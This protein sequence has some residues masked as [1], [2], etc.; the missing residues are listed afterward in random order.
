MHTFTA[1]IEKDSETGLFVGHI[2]G[3]PGAYS[4][5]ET[6]EELKDNLK[7]V[8]QLLLED[9]PPPLEAEFVGTAEIR[10]A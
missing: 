3:F 4:Q 6:V 1:V 2:P 5:G 9:G 8:V 10:V 7:E